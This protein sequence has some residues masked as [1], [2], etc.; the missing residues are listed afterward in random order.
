VDSSNIEL[1]DVDVA[2]GL[3]DALDA[4]DARIHTLLDELNELFPTTLDMLRLLDLI[5]T[6]PIRTSIRCPT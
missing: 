6:L 2:D 3:F 1:A 4:I 5:L